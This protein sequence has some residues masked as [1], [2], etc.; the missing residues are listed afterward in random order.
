MLGAYSAAWFEFPKTSCVEKRKENLTYFKMER[1]YGMS[2]N[3]IFLVIAAYAVLVAADSDT[4]TVQAEFDRCRSV[5]DRLERSLRRFE[6]LVAQVKRADDDGPLQHEAA[7]LENRLEYFR[8]RFERARGQ[9][10]KITGDLKN[11]S[12]PTCPSCVESSVGMYCRNGETIQNSLDD[13]LVKAE[14]LL[15]RT[16]KRKA[17]NTDS[18]SD[19]RQRRSAID[20][21]YRALESCSEPAAAPLISQTA[22]NLSRAD[23][24]Q[25]AGDDKAA[26]T[27]LDIAESLITKARRRCGSK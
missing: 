10:D 13:Y 24:L 19:F 16:G 6:D 15:S 23:S 26:A 18:S 25:A 22:V 7:A 3:R 21:L 14:D 8:N 27:A 5:M 1:Q 12:G 11:V 2:L 9:A 4:R 20:S 17:A